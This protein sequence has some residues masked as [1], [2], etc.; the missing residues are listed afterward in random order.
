[1]RWQAGLVVHAP[2]LRE[3]R[4]ALRR[5]QARYARGGAQ[6]ATPYAASASSAATPRFVNR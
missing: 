4:H 5:R 2:R 3:T 6:R 1:M